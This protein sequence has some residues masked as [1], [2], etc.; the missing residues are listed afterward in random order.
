VRLPRSELRCYIDLK[1]PDEERRRDTRLFVS[2]AGKKSVARRVDAADPSLVPLDQLFEGSNPNLRKE[3]EQ[4]LR[5]RGWKPKH[6]GPALERFDR[7]CKMLNQLVP[8]TTVSEV[9]DRDAVE[10]F[11]RLNKGG[12]PLKQGDV[13]AAEL[14]S[15]NAADVLK[16]MRDFVSGEQRQR[17]GFGFSFAF[18]ALVL[19]HREAAQ[20]NTLRADWIEAPGPH[21]R[22]LRASWNATENALEKALSFLDQKMGWS[23]RAMVPSA[24][25][26]IVLAA[27]F[28]KAKF[29]ITVHTE[30]LYRRWLCL[31]ALRGIFQGSV[32]TTINRFHRAI[33]QAKSSPAEALVGALT[34]NERR[35]LGA[36]EF[37]SPSQLWGPATQVMHAW[38]VDSEAQDWK[39]GELID[40][41]A[42]A[43]GS[44]V[45]GGT[46]T[47][48]HIFPR[49]LLKGMDNDD[50]DRANRPA[51]YALLSLETND[52][53]GDSPAED[54]LKTLKPDERENAARQFFGEA[55]GDLLRSDKYEEFCSWRA[56]RL[57]EAI[58]EWIG[59]IN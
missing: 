18:R 48:H 17:L 28:D 15:G 49:E 19:F 12:A 7:A 59:A 36:E 24:N 1:A 27:A 46:L 32:E 40:E 45:S 26:V 44:D 16:R 25:A 5:A 34:R 43:G 13:R 31:T 58:D 39:T 14:A 57:A 33:R 21:G 50:V 38:L 35:R 10:V 55:A 41:L 3:T 11:S 2:Y 54:V 56:K 23:R 29:R 47:V 22:S 52:E 4:A 37:N 20:F 30:R 51:N 42:R 53:F 6:V 9:S 8:R